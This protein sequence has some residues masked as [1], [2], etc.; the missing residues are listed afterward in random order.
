MDKPPLPKL[1]ILGIISLI[2]ITILPLLKDGVQGHL[3]AK[4]DASSNEFAVIQGN[5]VVGTKIPYFPDIQVLGIEV[6]QELY[7]IIKCE[8][9]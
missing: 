1:V 3:N 8:N 7:N 2:G 4:N 6:S 9:I 5:S